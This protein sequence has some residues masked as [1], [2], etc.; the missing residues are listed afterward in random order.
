[1]SEI[2]AQ[3][4]Y[5]FRPRHG[6]QVHLGAAEIRAAILNLGKEVLGNEFTAEVVSEKEG[7]VLV[8]C[9]SASGQI[10]DEM[11]TKLMVKIINFCEQN[12]LE[13]SV[14]DME[15]RTRPDEDWV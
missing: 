5:T 7:T 6:H 13:V 4:L 15:V 11:D 10:V 12:N 1:M 3:R 14:G 2:F 9:S 8:S